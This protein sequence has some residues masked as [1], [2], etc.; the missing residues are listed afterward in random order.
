MTNI[1]I[2]ANIYLFIHFLTPCQHQ[3][4][5]HGGLWITGQYVALL[6]LIP[7]KTCLLVLGKSSVREYSSVHVISAEVAWV[8]ALITQPS[9]AMPD[10]VWYPQ[11][12][13]LTHANWAVLPGTAFFYETWCLC[14]KAESIIWASQ[15]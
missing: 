2:F 14:T 13:I 10:G 9:W 1:N 6:T 4:Y 3:G 7:H 8:H 5:F 12:N 11:S 15:Y